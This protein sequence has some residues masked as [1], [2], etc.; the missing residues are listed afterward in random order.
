MQGLGRCPTGAPGPKGSGQPNRLPEPWGASLGRWRG[1]PCR[2]PAKP[3]GPNSPSR[4][5]SASAFLW[6]RDRV[7]H[8]GGKSGRFA[9]CCTLSGTRCLPDFWVAIS[10]A[11]TFL[12]REWGPSAL[13][14]A[15]TWA[16]LHSPLFSSAPFCCSLRSSLGP[17]LCARPSV[18]PSVQ[19][20]LSGAP[21]SN[22]PQALQGLPHI[23]LLPGLLGTS[24]PPR[25]PKLPTP[26]HHSPSGETLT[27]TAQQP[28]PKETKPRAEAAPHTRRGQG[29][30]TPPNTLSHPAKSPSGPDCALA[31]SLAPLAQA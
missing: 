24:P 9:G 17:G 25:S 30:A 6:D 23:L 31:H 14:T 16:K 12:V 20:E 8:P 22:L 7:S 21:P 26:H 11:S 3:T 15:A 4:G 13:E 19:P 28:A 2:N 1:V 5:P 18:R 10:G 27:V 29:R